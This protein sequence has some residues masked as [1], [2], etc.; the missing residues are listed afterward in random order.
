MLGENKKKGCEN[1]FIQPQDVCW[2]LAVHQVPRDRG[3]VDSSAQICVMRHHLSEFSLEQR[4]VTVPSHQGHQKPRK[5]YTG[6]P[7]TDLK[8]Q[9]AGAGEAD[10]WVGGLAP[11]D[12]D[13]D[14]QHVLE[15]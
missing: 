11:R 2:A 7:G 12:S 15:S 13:W 5:A 1:T 8:K 9:V 3:G 14:I 6:Q 4:P 10:S